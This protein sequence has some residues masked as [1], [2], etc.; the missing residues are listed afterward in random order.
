MTCGWF[1][2][3]LSILLFETEDSHEEVGA[4]GEIR[5]LSASGIEF[6]IILVPE[7]IL[8]G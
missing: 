1:G 8:G 5:R 6:H 4:A 7:A 3:F 2:I